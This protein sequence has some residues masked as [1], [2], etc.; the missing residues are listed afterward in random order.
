[1]LRESRQRVRVAENSRTRHACW[2][3]LIVAKGLNIK[4]N[5]T[6]IPWECKVK[7]L[8]IILDSKLT[9]RD[10]IQYSMPSKH[11]IL[12]KTLYPFI[13]RSS[14]LSKENKMLIFKGIFQAVM[15]YAAPVWIKSAT[16]TFIKLK[17]SKIKF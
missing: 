14:E 13:N 4:F 7:H 5:D 11:K 1:M 10:H 12:I 3:L 8:G 2:I 9:F 17:F 15:F 6:N 16:P